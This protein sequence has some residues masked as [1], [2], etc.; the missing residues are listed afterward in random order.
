MNAIDPSAKAESA[1]TLYGSELPSRLL[2][3]TAQYPSPHVMSRPV[4]ASFAS[5]C[6][7]ASGTVIDGSSAA[8]PMARRMVLSWT[9]ANSFSPSGPVRP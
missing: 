7:W 4:A 2:L 6:N 5:T 8:R 3:G 1:L 9:T